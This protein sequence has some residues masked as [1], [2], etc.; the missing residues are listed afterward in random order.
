MEGESDVYKCFDQIQR[1][2]VYKILE[3]AGLPEGVLRAY[4]N[5]QEALVVRTTIAG[6]LG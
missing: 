5:F 2:I 3:E 6:G 1:L 4:R